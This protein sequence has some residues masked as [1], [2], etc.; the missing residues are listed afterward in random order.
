MKSSRDNQPHF[1]VRDYSSA[2]QSALSWLGDRYLLATPIHAPAPRARSRF[3][4]MAR[5]PR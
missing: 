2:V 1:P 4:P 5:T 3:S